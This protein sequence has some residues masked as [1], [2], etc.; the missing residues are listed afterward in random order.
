MSSPSQPS[1]SESYGATRELG[2]L[3]ERLRRDDVDRQHDGK[4]ERVLV[5]KLL[6]HLPADSTVSARPPR[7]CEHAELV[8]HLRAAGDEHERALDVAEQ[9][10]EVLELLLEQEAGVRGQQMRDRLGR[11]MRAMRRA[12]RVVDVEIAAV[13]E[14]ARERLVV[15]RLARI[16]ARVLE[17]AHAFVGQQ[18]AQ[19]GVDRLASSTS[20]DPRRSSAVRGASRRGS[21][22]RPRSSR[23]SSVGS[24]A[25]MRVSSATSPSSSGT[26]RSERTS[27]TLPATSASRTDRGTRTLESLGIRSTSR[28]EK[29]HSLSYQP[30]TFTCLPCAIVESPSMMQECGLPTMSDETIGSSVY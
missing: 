21:P 1:G 17:H 7:F 12:E 23:S 27:T 4:A 9:P 20:P 3:F 2:V 5:A 10:A 18:L 8:V 24:D 16:E 14:L 29:P 6:G 28:H 15:L 26:F 22:A 13:G 30:I 25:R 19:A 11:R